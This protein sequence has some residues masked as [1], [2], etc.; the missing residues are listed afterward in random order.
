ML[1]RSQ[2]RLAR[3]SSSKALPNCSSIAYG[4][5]VGFGAAV[6]ALSAGESVLDSGLL[7]DADPVDAEDDADIASVGFSGCLPAAPVVSSFM[8]DPCEFEVIF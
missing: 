2:R 8:S 1:F 7:S 6:G 4:S 3:C 5:D